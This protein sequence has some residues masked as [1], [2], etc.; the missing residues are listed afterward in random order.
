MA[1]E[2]PVWER[3]YDRCQRDRSII[4]TLPSLLEKNLNWS[5]AVNKEQK[6]V[7]RYI[8]WNMVY[9]EGGTMFMGENNSLS[10]TVN[11]FFINR[12][13]VSQDE[14]YVIMGK[15]PS[16]LHRR[17]YPVDQICWLDTEL[18]TKK[19]SKL[20]RLPL[21]LPFEAEWEYAAREGSYYTYDK[22]CKVTHRY[23][24]NPHRWDIDYGLRLVISLPNNQ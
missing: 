9:V 17:G 2:C 6:E 22:Y 23:G 24:V 3:Y 15:N 12:Y 5:P 4:D 14:W 8:L 11:S 10:V 21:Q 7:I 19:L 1:Q 13:E 16:N 20:S 18:F